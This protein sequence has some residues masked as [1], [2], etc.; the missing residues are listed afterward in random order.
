MTLDQLYYFRKLAE[1]QHFTKAAAK[2]YISQP[3]LSCSINN[4]E[5]ELGASLFQKKGRNVVLTNCGIEFYKCIEEVLAKLDDG[6]TMLK[7]DIDS[8][9]NKITIGTVPIFPGDFISKNIKSYMKS[10]T[11]TIFDIFTRM[12]NKEVINGINSGLYDL[13]FVLR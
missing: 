3:S 8:T 9:S 12:E 13:G 5:K 7:Q 11:Q 6:V 2:L 1:L 10:Y 4:L